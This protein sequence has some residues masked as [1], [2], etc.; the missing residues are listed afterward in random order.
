MKILLVEDDV[1]TAEII[2]RFLRQEDLFCDCI[3]TGEEAFQVGKLYDYAVIILDLHLPDM[4]GH[5]LL[6]KLRDAAISSPILILSGNKS[7]QDKVKALG[8][9]ADD[10]MTKPFEVEELI[11]RIKAL[12]RRAEGHASAIIRVGEIQLNL[13]TQH[14]EVAG[15]PLQLTGKE[16][17][18]LEFLL[19]RKGATVTKNNFLNRLYSGMDEPEEKIIDVFM[20]KIRRKLED[21]LGPTGRD[22]IET[23]W[24]R[25]Y[26]LREPNKNVPTASTIMPDA[27]TASNVIPVRSGNPSIALFPNKA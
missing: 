20:C 19:V 16:Y 10:Y 21:I 8:F 26:V 15:R 6:Q 13:D 1:P 9:G 4:N 7:I 22:Y 3:M 25:G 17:Q 12:A 24:G 27:P 5:E 18:I 14:I 2:Q 11:V 23:I